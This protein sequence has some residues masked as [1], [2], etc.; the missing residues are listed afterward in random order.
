MQPVGAAVRV[1]V[2]LAGAAR[3]RLERRGKR[4][5]RALVRRELDDALEPELAL[6][7][8]DGLAR[9]VRAEA[10]DLGAEERSRAS[11]ADCSAPGR[12]Y[13]RRLPNPSRRAEAFAVGCMRGRARPLPAA[14]R[15]RADGAD[16]AAHLR[17]A[18]PRADRRVPR[19]GRRVR[20]R[21]RDR[22]RRRARDRDARARRGG[23]RAARRRPDEHRRRGTRALPAARAHERPLVHDGARRAGRRRRRAGRRPTSS[24]RSSCSASWRTRPRATS[25]SPTPTRRVSTSSSRPAS[26]SA[27]SRSRSCWRST[28]PRER[29]APARRAARAGARG[30]A[31]RAGAPRARRPERQGRRR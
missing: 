14:A 23:A 1:A 15:A 2:Q 31:D 7:L 8:L 20:A 25:T 19:E 13:R 29:M 28:S 9:L 30:A 24:G 10:V 22:R 3:D 5:E 18:L 11:A 6:H 16:P 21:A 12:P 26:T 27:S 4:P 17:A